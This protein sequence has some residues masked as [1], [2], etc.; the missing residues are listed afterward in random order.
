MVGHALVRL[1]RGGAGGIVG[2]ELRHLAAEIEVVEVHIVRAPRAVS[3]STKT[4]L[5]RAGAYE[6]DRLPGDGE[7]VAR[8]RADD[9]MYGRGKD[10]G[11]SARA[12]LWPRNDRP[13]S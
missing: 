11:Q 2:V 12:V 5:S 10:P 13:F 8:G 4:S 7:H 6:R 3:G 9:L 1:A